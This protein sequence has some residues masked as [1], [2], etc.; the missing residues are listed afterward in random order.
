MVEPDP[1]YREAASTRSASSIRQQFS[2]PVNIE[3]LALRHGV[4][5][6]CAAAP[7]QDRA[8]STRSGGVELS[9]S[10]DCRRDARRSSS[11]PQFSAAHAVAVTL[12]DRAGLAARYPWLNTGDLAAGCDTRRGEGWFDGHALLAALRR[13][14]GAARRA[15]CSRSRARLRA[16]GRAGASRP[17]CSRSAGA[18]PAD[19]AVN[20]A[21][22]R[23]RALAA[24]RRH[25]AA[26]LRAQAQR[27]RVHLPRRH[28][29]L[30]A[31]DRPIR[32]VV[33]S[34]GR[35]VSMRTAR[36]IRIPTSRRR[37]SR[38]IYAAFETRA[39]P[40]LAHRVPAFEAIRMTSA[41]AGHYDYNTFDQNAFIGPV[42]GIGNLLLAS[43]FSGH[44]IAAIAR[45]RPRARGAHLLRRIPH[46]RSHA[47]LLLPATSANAPLRELNVI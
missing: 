4:P 15:L 47:A 38:W 10:G 44:G 19:Y 36:A 16:V 5:A 7:A 45:H 32:A 1:S 43:G 40:M 25:R 11:G 29:A 3:H 31:G 26:G 22:T 9:L 13:A 37:I 18:W 33:S 34:G 42:P 24:T 27:V 8:A 20:A 23:S 30:P 14:E 41:W 35:A 12:H 2:T 21:G 17:Q 46:H 6:R 39:W 28:S